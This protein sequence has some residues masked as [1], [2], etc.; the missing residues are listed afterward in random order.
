MAFL[1]EFDEVYFAFDNF[2]CS[3]G[4]PMVFFILKLLLLQKLRSRAIDAKNERGNF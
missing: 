4:I 1:Y 3:H 2:V